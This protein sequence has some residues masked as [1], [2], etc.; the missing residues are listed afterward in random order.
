MNQPSRPA[1]LSKDVLHVPLQRPIVLV[2]NFFD[3]LLEHIQGGATRRVTSTQDR[4]ISLVSI[5]ISVA[6]VD[7]SLGLVAPPPG[8]VSRCPIVIKSRGRS[9]VAAM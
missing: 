1:R 3:L 6:L 2:E 7:H 5:A 4:A 9:N 8:D